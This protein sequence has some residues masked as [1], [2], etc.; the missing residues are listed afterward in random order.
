M[1][2]RGPSSSRCQRKLPS[3]SDL[4]YEAKGSRRHRNTVVRPGRLRQSLLSLWTIPQPPLE[5][6]FSVS[7]YQNDSVDFPCVPVCAG[8]YA[9]CKH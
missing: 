2:S 8:P 5:P 3:H 4:S 9:D 7:Q 6:L 1:H